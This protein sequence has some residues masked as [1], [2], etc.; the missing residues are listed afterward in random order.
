MHAATRTR[1]QSAACLSSFLWQIWQILDGA[2][3]K[4]SVSHVSAVNAEKNLL[5]PTTD[6]MFD[7]TIMSFQPLKSTYVWNISSFLFLG[8]GLNFNLA[9]AMVSVGSV[10]GIPDP[11]MR[12]ENNTTDCALSSYSCYVT[13]NFFHYQT[14]AATV[15]SKTFLCHFYW[16]CDILCNTS[17]KGQKWLVLSVHSRNRYQPVSLNQSQRWQTHRKPHWWPLLLSGTHKPDFVMCDETLV[18]KTNQG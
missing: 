2:E 3:T 16:E 13:Y 14:L 17:E 8:E 10:K 7:I 5:D 4:V 18:W 11:L 1:V 15:T 9:L 12:E 6:D